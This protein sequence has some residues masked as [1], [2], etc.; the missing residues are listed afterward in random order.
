M[1]VAGLEIACLSPS[2]TPQKIKN[3]LSLAHP[4]LATQGAGCVGLE[5]GTGQATISPRFLIFIHLFCGYCCGR[6]AACGY[7][8]KKAALR[9][10]DRFLNCRR[11]F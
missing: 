3:S 9:S 11:L 6:G 1:V 2:S 7:G 8:K 10:A 4:K 5:A